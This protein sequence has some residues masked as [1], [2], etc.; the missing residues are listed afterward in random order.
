MSEH[1]WKN[2]IYR[3]P[4][5]YRLSLLPLPFFISFFFFFFLFVFSLLFLLLLLSF[6]SSPSSS[7]LRIRLN[8][9]E[10]RAWPFHAIFIV[11][12]KF[13][14]SKLDGSRGKIVRF[15]RSRFFFQARKS[16]H[17]CFEFFVFEKSLS[18][19]VST[20]ESSLLFFFLEIISLISQLA[21][22][23]RRDRK[24]SW[25]REGEGKRGNKGRVVSLR[26][27]FYFLFTSKKNREK[28]GLMYWGI[29]ESVR[30]SSFSQDLPSFHDV[31]SLNG[32]R[33]PCALF[34]WQHFAIRGYTSIPL[35]FRCSNIDVVSSSNGIY[36]LSR[37]RIPRLSLY[38]VIF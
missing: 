12:S 19:H 25:E 9:E 8:E 13:V 22:S 11:A 34:S 7:P 2:C 21:Y 15:A 6:F 38:K 32:G 20:I 5:K 1:S 23:F 29:S 4:F 18:R 27:F 33:D 16:G 36:I 30:R 31:K 26:G 35:C 10:R 28:V 24:S 3:Y 14:F 17:G 37:N